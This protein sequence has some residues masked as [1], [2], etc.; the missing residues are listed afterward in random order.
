MW[1]PIIQSDKFAS[2]CMKLHIMPGLWRKGPNIWIRLAI[3]TKSFLE[4]TILFTQ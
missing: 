4:K 2:D 3:F 1:R